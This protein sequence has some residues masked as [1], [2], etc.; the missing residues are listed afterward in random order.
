MANQ[1]NQFVDIASEL[2]HLI[3]HITQTKLTLIRTPQK[4]IVHFS[5]FQSTRVL[6]TS[7]NAIL[8][9]CAYFLPLR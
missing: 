4:M 9:L 7:W 6:K 2:N 8:F 5:G 3:K 1:Q